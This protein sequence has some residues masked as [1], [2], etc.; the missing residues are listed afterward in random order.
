M[1]LHKITKESIVL[2]SHPII[3]VMI[4][5]SHD[6]TRVFLSLPPSTFHLSAGLPTTVK[7]CRT[8]HNTLDRTGLE[9]WAGWLV[10]RNK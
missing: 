8:V 1:T 10:L 6:N 9:G 4:I 3:I 7:V 5:V 2:L